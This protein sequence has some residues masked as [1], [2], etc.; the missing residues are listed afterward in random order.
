[1][2]HLT[3][4]IYILILFLLALGSFKSG[5]QWQRGKDFPTLSHVPKVGDLY[6]Q[7]NAYY[8]GTE[9]VWIMKVGHINDGN[10]Y[11]L[12][13]CFQLTNWP[14]ECFSA[15]DNYRTNK[16]FSLLF[17]NEYTN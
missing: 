10:V 14:G 13:R 16:S 8:D 5:E 9:E 4:P 3:T 15:T 17:K 2:K 7:Y 1:M 11:C 12:F 6:A